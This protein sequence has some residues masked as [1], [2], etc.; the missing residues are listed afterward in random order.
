MSNEMT[1]AELRALHAAATEITGEAW[2]HE[3]SGVYSLMHHGWERG[4]E[5]FRNLLWFS[6][7]IDR[8]Q[9]EVDRCKVAE[10]IAAAHNNLPAIL[11]RVQELEAEV[12]RLKAVQALLEPWVSNA[13]LEAS[14]LAA[15]AVRL[16]KWADGLAH[17][18]N[19]DYW[20]TCQAD[21]RMAARCV[22]DKAEDL[23]RKE[24]PKMLTCPTCKR[25][26]FDRTAIW[27]PFS[28]ESKCKCGKCGAWATAP[29][30]SAATV[31]AIVKEV[32]P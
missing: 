5:V 17:L 7:N 8:N 12:S 31:P 10:Y 11:D 6:A 16:E 14:V 30:W 22:K 2:I 18:S 25:K 32:N 29:D 24:K 15:L 26:G 27:Y 28:T 20:D 13:D 19:G 21:L 23:W 9:S 3:G 4:K 1:P